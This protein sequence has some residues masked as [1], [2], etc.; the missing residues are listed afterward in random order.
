MILHFISVI[1]SRSSHVGFAGTPRM[2]GVGGTCRK[3]RRYDCSSSKSRRRPSA[4]S[5][6][7]RLSAATLAAVA[8]RW[9]QGRCGVLPWGV[10]GRGRVSLVT[11]LHLDSVLWPRPAGA[12]GQRVAV[13]SRVAKGSGPGF[14]TKAPLPPLTTH[15]ARSTPASGKNGAGGKEV[16]SYCVRRGIDRHVSNGEGTSSNAGGCAGL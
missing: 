14:A 2:F 13:R 3:S 5:S 15:A 1:L 12:V 6:R 10:L 7:R 9:A 8:S 16:A 4:L 11:D